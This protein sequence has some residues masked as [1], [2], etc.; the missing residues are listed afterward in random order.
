MTKRTCGK[1]SACC[2]KPLTFED[3]LTDGTPVVKK[4]GERCVHQCAAGCAVYSLRPK[5][6]S[7]YTCE[8]LRGHFADNQKPTESGY[9][10]SRTL[11]GVVDVHEL[12]E[13]AIKSDKSFWREVGKY[14]RTCRFRTKGIRIIKYGVN[15]RDVSHPSGVG[16]DPRKVNRSFL[17]RIRNTP[18]YQYECVTTVNDDAK[19]KRTA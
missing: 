18:C 16:F 14:L 1:C 4:T 8:W 19:A 6:C 9:L 5:T 12:A 2:G 3:H 11:G 17:G 13:N 7:G 10:V 15:E